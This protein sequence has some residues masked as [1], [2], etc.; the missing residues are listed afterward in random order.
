MIGQRLQLAGPAPWSAG[1]ALSTHESPR[2]AAPTHPADQSRI[3]RDLVA[4]IE[5]LRA[6]RRAEWKQRRHPQGK[7]WTQEE[8]RDLACPSYK[9]LLLGHTQRLPSRE[10]VLRIAAY[11]ECS[12]PECNALLVAAQYLPEAEEIE[13]HTLA[14]LLA[15]AIQLVDTL[16]LPACVLGPDWTVHA[17]NPSFSCLMRLPPIVEIPA[18]R[19]TAMHLIFDRGLPTRA[20]LSVTPQSWEAHA[21]TAI[22]Q[23]KRRHLLAQRTPWYRERIAA[24]RDLPDFERCWNQPLPTA[25]GPLAMRAPDDDRAMHYH[26]AH[27]AVGPPAYPAIAMLTPA[28]EPAR[29]VFARLGAMHV[30]SGLPPARQQTAVAG[31]YA[32]R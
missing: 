17:A 12:V 3:I 19:R 6:R 23:F 27:V 22:D 32:S 29:M 25:A 30:T 13:Q 24:W 14:A 9:N 4:E 10:L 8:L 15:R 16:P 31:A 7:A 26:Q 11:L 5:A 2:S 18:A 21:H 20:R 28:D 1:Q